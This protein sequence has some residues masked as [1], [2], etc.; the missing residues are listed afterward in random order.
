MNKRARFLCI[1]ISAI[2]MVIGFLMIIY[3][4]II[5]TELVTVIFVVGATMLCAP[6]LVG[7]VIDKLS[8]GE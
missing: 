5:G 3:S 1:I 2:I 4:L 6:F 7:F 8:C